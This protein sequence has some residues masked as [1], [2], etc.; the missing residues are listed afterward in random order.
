MIHADLNLTEARAWDDNPETLPAPF[1]A[2]IAF[3]LR[4][5]LRVCLDEVQAIAEALEGMDI[6]PKPGA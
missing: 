2:D 6:Q 1:T 5:A 3:G 4:M